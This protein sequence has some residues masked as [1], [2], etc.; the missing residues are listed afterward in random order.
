MRS[1]D[2]SASADATLFGRWFQPEGRRRTKAKFDAGTGRDRRAPNFTSEDREHPAECRNG[3]TQGSLAV[4]VCRAGSEAAPGSM[5]KRR[6]LRG[7]AVC[8][9][10]SEAAP[11][12]AETARLRRASPFAFAVPVQ[13]LRQR[14][15]HAGSQ[16][17]AFIARPMVTC[18]ETPRS[19]SWVPL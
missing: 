3:E 12:N 11:P 14:T 1:A 8:R 18:S 4:C 17:P 6:D 2:V 16:R 19:T 13:R 15:N 10:Q 5:Q 7:L 9:A